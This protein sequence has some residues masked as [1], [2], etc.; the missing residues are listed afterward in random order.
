VAVQ[1]FYDVEQLVT[2]MGPSQTFMRSGD[3]GAN[4]TFHFCARCGTTL[5]WFPEFRPGRVAVAVGAFADK[6]FPAPARLVWSDF[7][8]P[9]LQV[10]SGT[11][12]YSGNAPN[13]APN[14]NQ[15]DDRRMR[16]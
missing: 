10:P 6:S 11:T 8:H 12:E 13:A 2:V 9:W 15:D 3:S 4:V 7:R 5:Y 16:P 1:A 14:E